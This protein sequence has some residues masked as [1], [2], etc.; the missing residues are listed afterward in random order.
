ML[1][2]RFQSELKK[3]RTRQRAGKK[4]DVR[5]LKELMKAQQQFLAHMDREM[6]DY[7]DVVEG[8]LPE[9]DMPADRPSEDRDVPAPSKRARPS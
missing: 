4:T 2:D 3:L 6:L 8:I 5:A 1:V 9:E 7:E